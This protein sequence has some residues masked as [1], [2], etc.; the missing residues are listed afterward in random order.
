MGGYGVISLLFWGGLHIDLLDVL[1][2]YVRGIRVKFTPT[3]ASANEIVGENLL[4]ASARVLSSYRQR[5]LVLAASF[6]M[7]VV[8]S[9]FGI[10][11]PSKHVLSAILLILIPPLRLLLL[12]PSVLLATE[13][14]W[15]ESLQ[16]AQQQ[17]QAFQNQSVAAVGAHQQ[18]APQPGPQ[19]ANNNL[20]RA[21]AR[22]DRMHVFAAQQI[23]LA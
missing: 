20:A 6:A 22:R 17:I 21:R 19:N 13:R 12:D 1:V 23:W 2:S 5:M 4:S 10:L 15:R 3:H 11:A 14:T 18:E 8:L 7:L 9:I 16:Q